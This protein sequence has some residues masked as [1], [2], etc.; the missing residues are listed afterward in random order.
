[1]NFNLSILRRDAKAFRKVSPRV[2]F[3]LLALIELQ[4]RVGDHGLRRL[5]EL[6]LELVGTK[7]GVS[8]RSVRRWMKLYSAGGAAALLSRPIRGRRAVVIRG[9]L[10]NRI[11][12]W[13]KRYGWGAE[14]IAAHLK[15][16]HDIVVGRYR[17]ERYLR[18]KSLLRKVRRKP[19][20][21]HTRRVRVNTPG[22]HTQIDVKYLMRTLTGGRHC[23]VYSFVDHASRWR[24][25]RAYEMFGKLQTKLFMEDL[26][27]VVP[28]PIL[29]LQ[30]DNGSEFTNHLTSHLDDPKPHPLD[31]FCEAQGI[32]HKLI[33]PGVK[34]LQGLVER[35]H[36]Q[37]DEEVY[38]RHEGRV[39]TIAGLNQILDEYCTWANGKR[40]R[41]A[42][43]WLTSDQWLADWKKGLATIHKISEAADNTNDFADKAA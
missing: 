19:K 30:S 36:R 33:P 3:R 13:R 29:R 14:V 43:G 8:G 25:K 10:A 28:F 1:M 17:I 18:R 22:A 24:F 2:T 23:Y 5:K 38:H 6:D 12:G 32:R 31:T 41:K 4:K 39:H 35:S 26:L 21:K 42:L 15:H 40:R 9:R 34:E 16:D 7:L 11:L 27:R 37:D 20:N